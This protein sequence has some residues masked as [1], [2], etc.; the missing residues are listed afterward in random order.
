MS[1]NDP[2]QPLNFHT[3][4]EAY[5]LWLAVRWIHPLKF[6][7]VIFETDSKVLFLAITQPHLLPPQ[8]SKS[9]AR[10]WLKVVFS[11]D[12]PTWN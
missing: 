3:Q 8:R 9:I 2:L 5:P 4:A 1:W 7:Q 10:Y 6:Q 11:S 12:H